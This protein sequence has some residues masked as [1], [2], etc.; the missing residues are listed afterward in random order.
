MIIFFFIYESRL[1]YYYI[2]KL[3]NANRIKPSKNKISKFKNYIDNVSKNIHLNN[4]EKT[5][6]IPSVINYI[7]KEMKPS[8][9]IL[10]DTE[11]KIRN[12]VQDYNKNKSISIRK[13]QQ[14]F[15]S[16]YEKYISTTKINNILR[17]KLNYHYIKTAAKNSF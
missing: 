12:I 8:E 2:Q 4:F 16:K 10:N 9:I 17:K 15:I 1:C 11:L 13:I 6:E 5:I 3:N 7:F 14:I